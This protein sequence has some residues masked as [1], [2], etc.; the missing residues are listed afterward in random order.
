[1]QAKK[2]NKGNT[3]RD[4]PWTIR[5]RWRIERVLGYF[6]FWLAGRLSRK[7]ALKLANFLGW[8]LFKLFRKYRQV[9][10]DGLKIAFKD[11]YTDEE[12][13]E[14]AR[15]SQYNL[16]RTVMDFL[17]FRQ[18][19]KEEL[20]ALAPVVEGREYLEAA[21]AR[22]DGGVIGFTGHFGSWEYCGAWLVAS[23]WQLYAVGKE[24][25]D[26][27]VTKLMLDARTAVGIKH[28]SKGGQGNR[29]LIRSIKEKNAILGLLSDQNGGKD[30]IFVDFFGHQASS[31]RGPAAIARRY[32]IPVV[33][34][35]AFWDGDK[36][37][38]EIYPEVELSVTDDE[39]ADEV[40]NTQSFMKVLEGMV[41]KYP[42]QWLW[43]HRRWKTRP[44][45]EPPLH[46]N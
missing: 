8:V 37:R 29:E 18:Y 30:G 11:E 34:L 3:R 5:A 15:Q 20:L 46:F 38:I 45:G 1:M 22:S 31:V 14:L 4:V 17:K 25:R 16:V 13:Y 32:G 19:S 10:I 21:S 12:I 36:Y 44:P 26:P 23:G 42:G 27:G 9:C 39:D 28:I 43:A 24:Q 7:S 2:E 40:V 33:P 41:R 35:F 6:I